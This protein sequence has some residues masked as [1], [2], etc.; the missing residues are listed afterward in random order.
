[1]E[2]FPILAVAAVVLGAFVCLSWLSMHLPAE[3]ASKTEKKKNDVKERTRW[4]VFHLHFDKL[5]HN[6]DK[7]ALVVEGGSA[8]IKL[9]R[10]AELSER[11][12]V[13]ADSDEEH[14]IRL[15]R[16]FLFSHRLH[17][18]VDN[19]PLLALQAG[20][21]APGTPKLEFN[22][23]AY[24]CS[25]QGDVKHREFELRR[26]NRL[27]AIVSRQAAVTADGTHEGSYRVETLKGEKPLPI[28]GVV[29][30]LEVALGKP[31]D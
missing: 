1:M 2:V 29:V 18:S 5:H 7:R 11:H 19:Q 6:S 25:V 13:L 10:E 20:R 30:G 16:G 22:K 14:S 31:A 3:P 12:L 4:H 9:F 21:R 27:V 26:D 8:G 24:K 17:I 23:S 28:L 15:D